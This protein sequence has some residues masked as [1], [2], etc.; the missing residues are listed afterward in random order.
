MSES[1]PNYT[2]DSF[3]L[4]SKVNTK[5]IARSSFHWENISSLLYFRGDPERDYSATAVHVQ[6]VLTSGSEPPV[7]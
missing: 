5:F 2:S 4:L 7:N 3:L 6:G 1:V